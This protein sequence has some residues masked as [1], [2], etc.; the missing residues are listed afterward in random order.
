MTRTVTIAPVRKSVTVAAS[1]E[2]AFETFA[3][4]IGRWWPKGFGIG[5]SKLKDVQIEPGVGGRVYEIDEDDCQV[6]W[7]IV[8]AWEPYGRIVFSWQIT[9]AWKPSP[10][11]DANVHSEVEVRFVRQDATTTRVELEHRHFERL[12][13]EAGESMRK[14]VDGGWPGLMEKYA[15]LAA[16]AVQVEPARAR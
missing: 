13:S 3:L 4:R 9:S 8:L 7:G 1:Q 16:G 14:D 10:D 12:G 15:A 11:T 2:L 6:D 5:E